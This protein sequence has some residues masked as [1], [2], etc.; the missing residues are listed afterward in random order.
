[1]GRSFALPEARVRPRQLYVQAS[2][3]VGLEQWLDHPYGSAEIAGE[4]I[5]AAEAESGCR[6]GRIPIG[7]APEQGHRLFRSAQLQQRV[8]CQFEQPRVVRMFIE[9]RRQRGNRPIVV[10]C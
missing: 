2:I 8:P 10:S 1:S 9:K 5:R 7:G 4:E 3:T 6:I